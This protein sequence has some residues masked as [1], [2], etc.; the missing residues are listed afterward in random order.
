MSEQARIYATLLLRFFVSD[1]SIHLLL[2]PNLFLSGLY[3]SLKLMLKILVWHRTTAI[4]IYRLWLLHKR[5]GVSAEDRYELAILAVMC[6]VIEANVANICTNIPTL[7]YQV[8]RDWYSDRIY[9][10]ISAES[11]RRRTIIGFTPD[12]GNDLDYS[13]HGPDHVAEQ[14]RRDRLR[15][16]NF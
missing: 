4:S 2:S 10:T 1:E 14:R 16:I 6:S 7:S 11:A 15:S 9:G 3:M 5:F 8:F 13:Q 12:S